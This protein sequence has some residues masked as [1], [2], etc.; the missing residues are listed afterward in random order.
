MIRESESYKM[1]ATIHLLMFFMKILYFCLDEEL[2]KVCYL[3]Q[4]NQIKIIAVHVIDYN[5]ISQYSFRQSLIR[6]INIQ[7]LLTKEKC[8]KIRPENG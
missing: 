5:L 1:M 4:Q 8:S 7:F 3:K 2:P 6:P